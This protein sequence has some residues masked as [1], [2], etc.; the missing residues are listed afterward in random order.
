MP[1][2]IKRRRKR[3]VEDPA[4]KTRKVCVSV[5][6]HVLAQVEGYAA[7]AGITLSN[8]VDKILRAYVRNRQYL[9]SS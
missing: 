8:L 4:D 7:D 2:E 9:T 3:K 6:D 5:S 1:E